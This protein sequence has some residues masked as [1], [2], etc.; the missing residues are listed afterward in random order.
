MV[1]RRMVVDAVLVEG[2]SV[3]EVATAFGRSKSWVHDLVTRYRLEGDAALEERSRRPVSSPRRTSE[4]TEEAII[5]LRKELSELGADAGPQTIAWHLE[6]LDGASP[7]PA[8]IYRILARRGFITPEPRKRPKS[9]YVRF[10]ADQPNEC[11]Q[12]DVTHWTLADGTDVE[13]LNFIDDHSRLILV[14]DVRR[15]TKGPDVLTTY[16][17]ACRRWGIPASVLTDN[18]AVFNGA[19][20]GGITAFEVVLGRAGVVYKHS[21]PY[22]PQ[23]CGKVE[24]WHQ[25][26]KGFLAKRDPATSIAELQ[27]Q[28]DAVVDYY[29]E[30]R[31]HRARGRITPAAAY[32]ARDKAQPGMSGMDPHFRIRHDKVDVGGKVSLRFGNRMLHLGVGRPWRGT[33][34]RLYIAG[35]DIRVVSEDGELIAQTTID[36]TKGYQKMRKPQ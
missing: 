24:R 29:N 17:T 9:S 30:R 15:V 3:R 23:T 32:A 14:A 4:A 16:E 11:W 12:A 6:Q 26:L 31:P 27:G 1:L 25:T 20:R 10:E 21:R 22:H 13:I 33:R 35:D 7:S 8:T 36:L 5:R 2:R 19:S 28:V 18:G 34:V